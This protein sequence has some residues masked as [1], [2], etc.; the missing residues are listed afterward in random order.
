MPFVCSVGVSIPD[1]IATNEYVKELVLTESN[2]VWSG[3]RMRL[4]YLIDEFFG[5][6]GAVDRTWRSAD[7]LPKEHVQEAVG[8]CLQSCKVWDPDRLSSIIY[9]GIDRGFVE[10]AHASVLGSQLGF[11]HVRAFDI[12][13][14]CLGW[15]TA[16]E[17]ARAFASVEKPL[18]LIISAEF[19]LDKPGLVFPKAFQV[20]DEEVFKW[21]AA[22]FTLGEMATAT[23]IDAKREIAASTV[24]SENQHHQLC[25]VPI[26]KP[27]RFIDWNKDNS[28]IDE[29]CFVAN[30]ELLARAGYRPGLDVL[31]DQIT[32]SGRPDFILPHAFSEVVPRI[33]AGRLAVDDRLHNVFPRVGNIS[34]SSVPFALWSLS[35]T[36]NLV[37]KKIM[38]WIASAGMKHA[39]FDIEILD[40]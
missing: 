14:A 34:T 30:G 35:Q 1:F 31:R 37:G 7:S 5:K 20:R 17:A 39:A 9:C 36:E 26:K 21:K 22:A 38:G 10:P 6:S 16:C 40:N 4:S 18:A 33:V 12:A 11:N 3:D 24:R 2:R 19:P 13:D 29:G 15:F 8:N 27:R 23:L 32:Q 25:V 28:I